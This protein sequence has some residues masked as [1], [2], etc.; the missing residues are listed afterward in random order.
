MLAP[1]AR[2]DEDLDG[3][4][5]AEQD[6]RTEPGEEAEKQEQRAD[7]LSASRQRRR[8]CRIDDWQSVFEG[9]ELNRDRPGGEFGLRGLPEDVRNRDA[10]SE[11]DKRQRNRF[12]DADQA[13][14]T[15]DEIGKPCRGHRVSHAHDGNPSIW[16]NSS[17]RT[18]ATR[19]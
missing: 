2:I 4:R 19:P 15:D 8:D 9:E 3:C 16:W 14:E 10:S 7:K 5:H 11:L 6:Q 1:V 12:G 13:T 18:L 17:N